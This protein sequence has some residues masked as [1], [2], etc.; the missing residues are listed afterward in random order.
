MRTARRN[1]SKDLLPP[2]DIG[3]QLGPVLVNA[4]GLDLPLDMRLSVI[5]TITFLGILLC[6]SFQPV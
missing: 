4:S 6:L 1:S 3:K 5:L 2:P